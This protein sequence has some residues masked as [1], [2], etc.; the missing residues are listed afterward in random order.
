MGLLTGHSVRAARALLVPNHLALAPLRRALWATP[1]RA[2]D[3]HASVL[4][5]AAPLSPMSLS[6]P[7]AAPSMQGLPD[8]IALTQ[9]EVRMLVGVDNWERRSPQ[10]VRIDAIVH[11]DISAAGR[12][13]HL[14]YSLHY[15]TLTKALEKHC[16]HARYRSLEALAVR[17]YRVILWVCR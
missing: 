6:S 2:D 4:H 3:A 16:A 5:R 9:L 17:L 1:I 7:A 8:L 13:D 12:T 15:G 11:T 10:P 14:P